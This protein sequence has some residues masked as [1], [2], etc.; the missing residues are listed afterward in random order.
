[1]RLANSQFRTETR[2]CAQLQPQLQ[3]N[4]PSWSKS[5]PN[6]TAH[7][8][9]R[10]NPRN[11]WILASL[12]VLVGFL[13]TRIRDI[14]HTIIFTMLVPRSNPVIRNPCDP[15]QRLCR[16]SDGGDFCTSAFEDCPEVLIRC[17]TQE[18]LCRA[19]KPSLNDY[20]KPACPS[21]STFVCVV[22]LWQ[23][24]ESHRR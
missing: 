24:T 22:Q 3:R 12:L 20:C 2:N 7:M 1:M 18:H 10:L 17:P 19:S 16:D 6:H 13:G 9:R 4:P 5:R 15:Q 23:R 8:L 11:V 14:P 21:L